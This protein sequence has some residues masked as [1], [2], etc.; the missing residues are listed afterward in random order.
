M[1]VP[2]AAALIGRAGG[3]PM[4]MPGCD[5]QSP[6]PR[7]REPNGLVIGPFTGQMNPDAEA[8]D[9]ARRASPASRSIAP[10]AA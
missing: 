7:Q 8:A 5:E 2:A 6:L 1:T 10:A 9:A 4:S 3:T